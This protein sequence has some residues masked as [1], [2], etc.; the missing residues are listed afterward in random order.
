[1]CAALFEMGV[2][3]WVIIHAPEGAVAMDNSGTLHRQPSLSLPPGYIKGTV[4]AGDAFC[5]GVLYS[6]YKG[7][8]VEKAMAIGTAAAACCLS[9]ISATEGMRDIQSI[10]EL[11]KYMPKRNF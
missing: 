10:E 6:I 8:S 3:D 7:W 9:E 5:A 2:Q 1:M 4:G 11:F